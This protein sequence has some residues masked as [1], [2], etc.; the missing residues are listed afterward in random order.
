MNSK[1]LLLAVV[2]LDAVVTGDSRPDADGQ[3]SLATD[4]KI[5]KLFNGILGRFCSRSDSHSY[6]ERDLSFCHIHFT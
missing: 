1:L 6:L 4:L 3:L 2:D 5:F